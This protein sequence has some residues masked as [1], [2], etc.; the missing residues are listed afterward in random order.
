MLAEIRKMWPDKCALKL[1]SLAGEFYFPGQP[2][3]LTQDRFNLDKN[4]PY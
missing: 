1:D 4:R 3:V 2:R